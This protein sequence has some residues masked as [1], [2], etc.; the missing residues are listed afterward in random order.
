MR[1]IEHLSLFRVLRPWRQR[2][3]GEPGARSTVRVHVA[4]VD[5]DLVALELCI[6]S[7]RRLARYP[8]ELTVGYAGVTESSIALLESFQA[9]GW[10]Q[11]EIEPNGRSHPEW[12]DRWLAQCTADFAAF[13]DAD[14][15]F[16][17][18]GWL[19]DLVSA[20]SD[21]G[22]ALVAGEWC[23]EGRNFIEPVGGKTVRLAGRPA[24]W[25]LLLDVRRGQQMDASFAF[26]AD[27]TA[28]VPEGLIAYDVGARFYRELSESGGRVIVMPRRYRRKYRHYGNLSWAPKEKSLELIRERLSLSRHLDLEHEAVPNSAS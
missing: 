1:A 20:A 22:A 24:A 11:L 17:Q 8:F 15:E 10:L 26:H 21:S 14:V 23:R 12:L 5:A 27:E 13:V 19:S 4:C 6:R 7:M 9:R 3:V 2:V 16:L 28:S 18:D 25:L